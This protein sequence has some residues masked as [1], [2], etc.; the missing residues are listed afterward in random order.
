MGLYGA[1]IIAAHPDRAQRLVPQ[2]MLLRA[3]M[4]GPAFLLILLVAWKYHAYGLGILA[5]N[6][7]AILLTPFLTQWVFQGLRQMHFVAAG[8]ALRNFTFVALVLALVR[9]GS[10]IRLVALA[11]VSGIVVLALVNT[12]LLQRYVRLRMDWSDAGAGAR[13]VFGEVWFMGLSDFTWACLWYSPVLITGWIAAAASVAWIAAPIRVVL[14]L[15]TFVFLYFF[16]LL[17]NLAKE[18]VQGVAA[19]RVLVRR[20]IA[21]SLGPSV[22]LAVGGTIAA[23]WAIPMVFGEPYRPAILPFQ[24]AVWMIPVAWFSGHFRFSLIAAGQQWWEFVVSLVTAVVTIGL[25]FWLVSS[26]EAA[27]AATALLAGGVVNTVLAMWA[28][29]LYVGP[30]TRG[31]SRIPQI[32]PGSTP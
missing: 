30:I 10:D 28:S 25:G 16:N 3:L 21:V 11:E 9:P 7:L 24:I 5:V 2:V 17:P 15:H 20:S 29:H 27:G 31:R 19:W 23:P 26:Y 22:L 4:A 18:L 14:A 1:R 8:T 32:P 12:W 6:G 13:K